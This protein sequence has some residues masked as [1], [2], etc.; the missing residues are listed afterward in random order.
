[1]K[2]QVNK[3]SNTRHLVSIALQ[4]EANATLVVSKQKIQ[5]GDSDR[6]NGS[7]VTDTS[8]HDSMQIPE[9]K[10]PVTSTATRTVTCQQAG[11]VHASVLDVCEQKVSSKPPHT[12]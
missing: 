8:M 3:A 6:S 12:W 10:D 2:V 11:G 4:K 1:M 9:Q 5:R 7:L